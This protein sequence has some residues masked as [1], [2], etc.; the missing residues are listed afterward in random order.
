MSQL[1]FDA[2]GTKWSIDILHDKSG[3][4]DVLKQEILLEIEN[5]DKIFSRFRDDSL[6]LKIAEKS[7]RYILP[8]I[9][10]PLLDIY[11]KFF[12]LTK[13]KFTPLIG[14]ALEEAGYDKEY[15][16]KPKT[17]HPVPEWAQVIEINPPNLILKKPALLDFG[18]AGKGY[19]VDVIGGFLNNKNVLNYC[20]DAGGDI[21]YKNNKAKNLRVGMENPDDLRQVVGVIEILNQSVCASSGNRRKWAQYHHIIDPFT[22]TSPHKVKAVWVVSDTAVIADAVATC[23]FL[24]EP[25]TLLTDYSFDYTILYNDNSFKKSENFPGKLFTH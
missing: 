22:L 7:G 23:L 16:L 5:F 6:V 4:I 21:L 19:L 3:N 17:L 1:V 9:A 25:E 11:H 12:L 20:I 14:K 15:S 13:G 10:F 24:V 18:A 8:E 2:I